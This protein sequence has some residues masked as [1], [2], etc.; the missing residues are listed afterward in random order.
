M[1]G[2]WTLP[3][4]ASASNAW[5]A[6]ASV[7]TALRVGA[8]KRVTGIELN[9]NHLRAAT[10]GFVTATGVPLHVRFIHDGTAAAAAL[11]STGHDGIVVVGTSLGA[12]FTVPSQPRVRIAANFEV[13]H[14]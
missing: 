10:Q 3:P 13:I 6:S 9:I 11:D 4:S 12:G 8:E 1:S 2:I 7:G 5:R 14:Q